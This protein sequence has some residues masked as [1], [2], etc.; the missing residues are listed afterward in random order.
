[1]YKL[2]KNTLRTH[3]VKHNDETRVPPKRG[4]AGKQAV[5]RHPLWSN[6]SLKRILSVEYVE[7]SP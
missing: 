2:V 4:R 7:L 3:H 6:L 5:G 1:M